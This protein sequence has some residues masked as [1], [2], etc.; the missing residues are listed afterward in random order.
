MYSS[1][2]LVLLLFIRHLAALCAPLRCLHGTQAAGMTWTLPG[3][4]CVVDPSQLTVIWF[5]HESPF[6]YV[7]DTYSP[8]PG[9]PLL[10]ISRLPAPA[11]PPL[12]EDLSSLPA[13][14]LPSAEGLPD[15]LSGVVAAIQATNLQMRTLE[16]SYT[17]IDSSLLVLQEGAEVRDQQTAAYRSDSRCQNDTTPS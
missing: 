10:S 16:E 1:G 11:S 4:A 12:A 14:M 3:E 2:C 8:Y 5:M 9:S 13:G 6:I 15:E 7:Q 17:A